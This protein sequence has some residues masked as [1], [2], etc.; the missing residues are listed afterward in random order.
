MQELFRSGLVADVIL[1][2]M[3]LEAALLLLYRR[4]T[5]R[6]PRVV[7]VASMLL[8]GG[9]L[10]LALRAALTGADWRMIGACLGA[11]LIAHLSDLYRRWP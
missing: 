5:G 7:D 3:A 8:A 4:L 1:G 6:G 2:V 9:F 10:V 11:A